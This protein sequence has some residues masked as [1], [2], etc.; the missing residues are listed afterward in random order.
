MFNNWKV[1]KNHPIVFDFLVAFMIFFV[2]SLNYLTNDGIKIYIAGKRNEDL[3]SA[4][5]LIVEK[6]LSLQNFFSDWNIFFTEPF[7][8]G[9]SNFYYDAHLILYLIIKNTLTSY[10]IFIA[11]IPAVSFFSMYIL[12]YSLADK[13]KRLNALIAAFFYAL[14]PYVVFELIGHQY[15]MW[16]YALLPI[17]YYFIYRALSDDGEKGYTW[18]CVAGIFIALSAFYPMIQYMYINGIFLALFSLLLCFKGVSRTQLKLVLYR[19]IRVVIMFLTAFLLSAYFIFPMFLL[20]SPYSIG[21]TFSRWLAYPI[22]SNTFLETIFLLNR[23][24]RADIGLDYFSIYGA[25]TIPFALPIFLSSLLITIKRKGIHLIFFLLGMLAVF[26][27]MGSNAPPFLNFFAYARILPY[28]SSIRTP[29][30]FTIQVALSF[31]LLGGIALGEIASKLYKI[32][33]GLG[34]ANGQNYK[35][36]LLCL[37]TL[38]AVILPYIFSAYSIA[39]SVA[40]PFETQSISSTTSKVVEWLKEHDPNQDY[41]VI[42]LTQ[43]LQVGA[44]HRSLA[45]V[46]RDLVSKYYRSPSFAKILG[47]LNVKYIITDP[48]WGRP[49]FYWHSYINEILSNSPD[50]DKVEIGNVTIY[51]N[52]LAKPRIYAAYGALTLGGSN[53]LSTFYAL[54]EG[55]RLV[56]TNIAWVDETFKNGWRVAEVVNTASYGFETDSNIGNLWIVTTQKW[57]DYAGYSF[58][59]LDINPNATRYLVIRLKNDDNPASA[60]SIYLFDDLN[61]RLWCVNNVHFSDW[62]TIYIDLSAYTRRQIKR[63]LIYTV[64]KFNTSDVKLHTYIDYIAFLNEFYQPS[65]FSNDW[66]LF[67][68]DVLNEKNNLSQIKKFNAMVFHDSDLRDLTFLYLDPKFKLEAWKYLNRDWRIIEDHHGS[69]PSARSYQ[70]SVFGQLVFSERAIYTDKSTTLVIPFNIDNSGSYEVWIRVRNDVPIYWCRWVDTFPPK[71]NVIS[72]SVDGLI[73]GE[74]NLGEVG[75]FKWVKV[76]SNL[77]SL[78]KGDHVLT[79]FT[80]GNP[81]YLDM[82]AVTPTGLVDE[83][84]ADEMA[85]INDLQHVYLLEF[86]NY[87]A[88]EGAIRQAVI[89]PY[90]S[91]AWS[92]YLTLKP[93]STIAQRLF[94]AKDGSYVLGLRLLQRPDGGVLTLK[95]DD[96]VVLSILTHGNNVWKWIK[97]APIFLNSGE[98]LIE[99]KCSE[100]Y[101]SLDL[102]YIIEESLASHPAVDMAQIQ[103]REVQL[104][105]WHGNLSSSKPTFLVFTESYYPEW[106]FQLQG[107]NDRTS[108]ESLQAFY[109]LNAYY[110]SSAGD[111]KFM[112]RHETSLIRKMSYAVSISTFTICLSVIISQTLLKR[113]KQT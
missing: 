47:L 90:T 83:M 77:L 8:V 33:L 64:E 4:L 100:G 11:I 65:I 28:F 30:R 7:H 71:N 67:G 52:K 82:V 36:K 14:T 75:G 18:T 102:L 89:A 3:F 73:I 59:R 109:F 97:S 5:P 110:I 80:S 2:M 41:R 112:I 92:G 91:D 26:F 94:I 103:F 13:N 70:S 19:M 32:R 39:Y 106:V 21:F 22:Y 40:G 45:R 48:D 78:S 93:N 57:P 66:A 15:M 50:F 55:A 72:V 62:T 46:G 6:S 12:S 37:L 38:S 9:D 34:R 101:N 58:D 16:G 44:Y 95:I 107:E 20:Q 81:V 42:D 24:L 43:T 99:V 54:D 111:F 76:N 63:I 56:D 84:M 86:S 35:A 85:R 49:Y 79:L 98:H 74:V 25:L 61:N 105:T 60:T 68:T 51:I 23:G 29:C 96:K 10:K 104:N 113:R 69:L 108:I 53:A 31:S 17:T 1:V 88:G 27:S 87:F